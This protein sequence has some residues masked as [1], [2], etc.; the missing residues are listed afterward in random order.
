MNL[1]NIHCPHCEIEF[2]CG[3]CFEIIRCPYCLTEFLL[4][5]GGAIILCPTPTAS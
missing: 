1:Y 5:D 2:A 4:D 3:H